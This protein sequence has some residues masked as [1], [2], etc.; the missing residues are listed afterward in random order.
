VTG[1]TGFLGSNL[2]RAL[3][4]CGAEVAVLV[5][6][7]NRLPF[8]IEAFAEVIKGDLGDSHA[9]RE[10]LRQA[11][12][13]FHCAATTSNKAEWEQHYEDT[14]MGTATICEA[15]AAESVDRLVH[16]SSV[17]V[18]GMNESQDGRLIG[19]NTPLAQVDDPWDKYSRAKVEAEEVVR[20]YER[21]EGLRASIVRPGILYGPARPVR[22][23]VIRLGTWL[24]TIGSARNA[25]PYTYVGNAVD[26]LLLTALS[27]GA[28]GEAFN[29]VD[30]PQQGAAAFLSSLDAEASV[31]IIPFPARLAMFLARAAERRA[32]ASPAAG[33]PKLTVAAV[34]GATRDIRYATD[35]AR[36][37]LGWRSEIRPAEAMHRQDP[38][39][40]E[41]G[42]R[43]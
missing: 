16:V 30:D 40:R 22:G 36:D 1:A 20:R 3:H 15:A 8:D 33:A 4:R 25:L 21:E 18:Y 13:V 26:A 39:T 12:A 5:R 19:E 17:A 23:G 37:V 6:D 27:D 31:R 28:R 43:V 41:L 35:K 38:V 42:G 10:A 7:P 24:V 14:V 32:A 11:D 2:A 34:R 9:V 29:I